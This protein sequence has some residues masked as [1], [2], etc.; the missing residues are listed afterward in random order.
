M[1][2]TLIFLLIAAGVAFSLSIPSSRL[3]DELLVR[4]FGIAPAAL[5]LDHGVYPLER[6]AGGRRGSIRL[7][8]LGGGCGR[9]GGGQDCHGRLARQKGPWNPFD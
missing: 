6:L 9:S 1:R 8:P 5:P 7:N 2:Q 4:L 3:G